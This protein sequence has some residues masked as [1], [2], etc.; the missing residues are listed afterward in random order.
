MSLTAWPLTKLLPLLD[1]CSPA[2][3]LEWGRV[4][5]LVKGWVTVQLGLAWGVMEVKVLVN[6]PL[7]E[8][9]K[10]TSVVPAAPGQ[11]GLLLCLLTVV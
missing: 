6:M 5:G 4:Q 9:S 2:R 7:A 10:L 3:P 11:V 1:I 8:T